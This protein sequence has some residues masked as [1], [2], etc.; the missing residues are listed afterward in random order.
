M[1][2][3]HKHAVTMCVMALPLIIRANA[4]RPSDIVKWSTTPGKAAAQ[5]VLSATVADGWHIYALSQ[6][7]G[8]PTALKITTPVGSPYQIQGQ[9]VDTGA[10][11]HFDTNFNMETLYYT[12]SASFNLTLKPASSPATET[13]PIDVRF[14]ACSDRLCLP[15]Y[16]AHLTASIKGK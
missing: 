14:Q 8:G 12:K 1:T 13:A 6:A 7:T 2:L 10:T 5:V 15:P 11:R 4:Q 9:I 3:S 16:T